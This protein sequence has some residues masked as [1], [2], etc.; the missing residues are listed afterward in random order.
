M[1]LLQAHAA[2]FTNSQPIKQIPSSVIKSVQTLIA[3]IN[4]PSIKQRF[5]DLNAETIRYIES[6]NALE[7]NKLI[8]L[9]IIDEEVQTY[10]ASMHKS[11]GPVM[12]K[13][14][15][16]LQKMIFDRNAK[17][18][19]TLSRMQRTTSGMIDSLAS[20]EAC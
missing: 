7:R 8:P 12:Q 11:T 19:N 15:Q 13:V 5:D 18:S 3:K 16:E 2:L 10:I 20:V 14:I 17:A 6:S 9:A 4:D 1:L